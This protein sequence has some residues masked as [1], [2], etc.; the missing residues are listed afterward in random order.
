MAFLG[1]E[2]HAKAAHD[3]QGSHISEGR[4]AWIDYATLDGRM[5]AVKV[6]KSQSAQYRL[7]AMREIAVLSTVQHENLMT[8]LMVQEE[9]GMPKLI[10]EWCAGGDLFRLLHKSCIELQ[11]SHQVKVLTD[12]A[13]GMTFLHE[14]KPRIMHRDLKSLNLLLQCA[15]SE[16]S[17]PWVKVSDF[18]SSRMQESS[19]RAAW[20]SLT[21]CVGTWPWMAP[22]VPSGNYDHRAD[23]YSFAMVMFEVFAGEIP[24]EGLEMHGLPASFYRGA[25][26]DLDAISPEMPDAVLELL[27]ASWSQDSAERPTFERIQQVITT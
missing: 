1:N 27:L 14:H 6:F 10:I 20:S 19:D 16:Q 7:A 26:P 25:V 11:W 9:Q 18:G 23:L 8:M 15:Y 2:A 17:L 4:T 5:V 13:A 12:V 3:L 21:K 24:F 22:E